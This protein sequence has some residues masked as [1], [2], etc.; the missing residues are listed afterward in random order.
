MF[1]RWYIF[2]FFVVYKVCYSIHMQIATDLVYDARVYGNL[3]DVGNLR[4]K[5]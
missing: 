1:I 2:L 4:K 3:V 5:R